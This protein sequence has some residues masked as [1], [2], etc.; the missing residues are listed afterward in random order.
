MDDIVLR[1]MAR[2][3]DVPAVFGWLRLDRRGDWRI[4]DERIG[5]PAIVA[6]ISRNYA[7]DEQGRW[8]FQNGPQRVFVKLDYAPFVFRVTPAQGS[9]ALLEAHTGS[10]IGMVSG[11]WIDEDGSLVLATDAGVGVVDDRDLERLVPQFG[12][13]DGNALPEEVLDGALERLQQG[14]AVPLQLRFREST[15]NVVSIRS[16]EVPR[17]FAFVRDPH[18]D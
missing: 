1:A 17:R 6:Y 13:A 15:L 14:Q 12:D 7:H 8:F 5:N 9:S 4:R 2:W 10:A 16:A 18:P 3:P 11:A